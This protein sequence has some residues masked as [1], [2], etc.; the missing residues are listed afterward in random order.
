M[1]DSLDPSSNE[2]DTSTP[3]AGGPPPGATTGGAP[4]AP[5][6]AMPPQGGPMAGP[7]AKELGNQLRGRQLAKAALAILEEAW[8]AMR[9]KTDEGK[10]LFEVIGKLSKHFGPDREE[11]NKPLMASVRKQMTSRPGQGAAPAA[12][13]QAPTPPTGPIPR[14]GGAPGAMGGP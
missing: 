9:S 2:P 6:P 10:V 14:P 1:P 3:P 13:G 4:Q 8:S 11:Q 5:N 12:G 7:P